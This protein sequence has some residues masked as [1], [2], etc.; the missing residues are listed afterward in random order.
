MIIESVFVFLLYFVQRVTVTVSI[1]TGPL[2][3]VTESEL[4]ISNSADLILRSNHIFCGHLMPTRY[5]FPP[6]P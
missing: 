1:L 2:K 3:Y 5:F 4:A 6:D